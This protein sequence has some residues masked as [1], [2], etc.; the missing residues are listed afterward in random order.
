MGKNTAR[1]RPQARKANT[2]LGTRLVDL[3]VGQGTWV[4]SR[5]TRVVLQPTAEND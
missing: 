1:R 3:G 2:R 5:E 4:G